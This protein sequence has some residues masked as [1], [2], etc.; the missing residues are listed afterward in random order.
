MDTM[1]RAR[2]RY[3]SLVSSKDAMVKQSQAPRPLDPRVQ[4]AAAQFASKHS[5]YRGPK[6]SDPDSQVLTMLDNQVTAAGFDPTTDAYWQELESRGKRYLGHR[7]GTSTPSNNDTGYNEPTQRTKPRSPVGGAV[8]RANATNNEGEGAFK[9]S[10]A[11][12]AAM[13]EAGAW[14]DPVRRKNLIKEY[15]RIDK[16]G[17]NR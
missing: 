17:S 8:Q 1:F 14:D 15:Q 5:W 13:K 10:A 9:L 2:D 4:S 11:R 12:V 16:Q 3:A 7:F 6:A